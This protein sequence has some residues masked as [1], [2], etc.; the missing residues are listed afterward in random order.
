MKLKKVRLEDNQ[1]SIAIQQEDQWIPLV[2]LLHWWQ[3]QGGNPSPQ[4]QE[5]ATD[6]ILFLMHREIIESEVVSV[7]KIFQKETSISLPAIRPE[8]LLPFNPLSFRDF[9]LWEQHFIQSKAGLIRQF[10]PAASKILDL[11]QS[12][13]RKPHPR[14]KPPSLFYQVPVYYMGNHIQ[15]YADGQEIPWPS[16]SDYL[17]YE[18]E[19]AIIIAKPVYNATPEEALKA[20]GGF[21]ILNDFSARDQQV[22]EFLESPFGPVVKAK[23]FGSSLGSVVVTADE[24]LPQ[25]HQLSGRVLVNGEQ[26]SQGTTAGMAHSIGEVVA[27]ACLEERL[28]P[29]EVLGTGTL[30]GCAGVEIGRWIKP[31]DVVRL[32]IDGIGTLEN[33]VVKT[34]RSI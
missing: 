34:N 20:V 26:W 10:K 7:L 15:F 33:R 9:M 17:D 23:N 30:P 21:S 2:P 11:Y 5:A 4:L 31:G 27:Y 1:L 14:L 22:K 3:E 32:E 16:Y 18:L 13:F 19:L 12:I 29:G 25:I 28:I 6:L 24:I 8:P